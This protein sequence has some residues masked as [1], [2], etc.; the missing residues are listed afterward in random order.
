MRVR[1]I[2]ATAAA[3]T[4]IALAG[5]AVAGTASAATPFLIPQAGAAGVE[6]SPGETQALAN[7]P[8][9]ALIDRYGP[10]DMVSVDLES[11]STLPQTGDAV[12]ADMPSIVGEAA[13]HPDGEVAL[14]LVPEGLV[15]LQV[16]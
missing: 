9:P 12:Y 11:D 15:V 7:S 16:W 8:I 10:R 13:S 14:A 4:G 1:T 5:S 6:L 2:A 3:C